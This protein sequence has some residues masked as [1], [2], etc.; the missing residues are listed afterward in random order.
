VFRK[1]DAVNLS[2]DSANKL[3]EALNGWKGDM[4][5]IGKNP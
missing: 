4:D 1:R 3:V 2:E 5:D